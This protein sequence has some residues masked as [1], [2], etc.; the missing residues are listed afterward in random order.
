MKISPS[1]RLT[2][3]GFL[4]QLGVS[5]AGLA[6]APYVLAEREDRKRPNVLLITADDLNW[7][8]LGVTGCAIPG[9]TPNIDG[10]AAQGMRF[11]RAY[12][13]SAVCQPSRSAIMTGRYPHRNGAIGFNDINTDVPTL[14]ES[15]RTAGYT[16]G[17]MAKVAHLT[18]QSKFCWDTVVPP[19]QLG[20]GRDPDAYYKF[21]KRFFEQAKS[22]DKPFFLMANSQ[23]PHRP[24]PDVETD[25]AQGR[26]VSRYYKPEEA[27]VPRFLPQNVPGLRA[28]V[29]Q[30]FTAVHRCDETVGQVLRALKE[31]GA[32][33]NT[34]VIFLS[35]NG[36]AFPF[37]KTNCYETS[38]RTPLIVRWPGRVKPSVNHDDYVSGID[39]MPTLLDAIGLP[40]VRG[41][42]GTSF[43]PLLER[44]KQAGRDHVFTF[45]STTSAKMDF[46]MRCVRNERHSFIYNT[47][48]D[49]KK[50]FR[51]ESR[52]S[53]SFRAMQAAAKSDDK[54]AKEIEFYLHRVPEEF[55]DLKSDPYEKNNLIDAPE[56]KDVITK[57]RAQ[58]LDMMVSTKDLLLEGFRKRL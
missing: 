1:T 57:M 36:M 19:A 7:D 9:V 30:Y 25:K 21:S 15:L 24:F 14:T 58:M 22:A 13:T 49:G 46:P 41:M 16:N 55:Y 23:D 27:Q 10:L 38:N 26:R 33:E 37:A 47:W 51:N 54:L 44:R 32:E 50:E 43:V 31:T 52:G 17:I 42:D 35:D 39:L 11:E 6:F 45:F 2:R 8:S 18:P 3:R 53:A 56:H 40:M 4:A 12:V 29:A 34:I 28:E 20:D 5:A 48:S